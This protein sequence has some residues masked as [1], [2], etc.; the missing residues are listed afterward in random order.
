MVIG[1]NEG[2]TDRESFDAVSME[3]FGWGVIYGSDCES[4]EA[5]GL[6]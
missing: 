6:G 2:R 4:A 5:L 3:A 1:G